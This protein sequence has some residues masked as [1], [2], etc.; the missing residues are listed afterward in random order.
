MI[1]VS[2]V[3]L[4]K[5]ID[6]LYYYSIL[7]FFRGPG[8]SVGITTGYG[9]DGPGVESHGGEIFRAFLDR[10]WYSFLLEAVSTPGQ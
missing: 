8:S 6:T 2:P 9:L 3:R 7:Y 1:K 5:C 4:Q 10:S